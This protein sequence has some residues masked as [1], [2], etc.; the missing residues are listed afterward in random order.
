MRLKMNNKEIEI[1]EIEYDEKKYIKKLALNG[2]IINYNYYYLEDGI[3]KIVDDEEILEYLRKN[4]E[5][6]EDNIVYD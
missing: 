3:E 4:Y 5:S 6:T 2:K 1:S